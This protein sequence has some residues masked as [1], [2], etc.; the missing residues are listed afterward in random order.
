MGVAGP[1]A[2]ST[3]DV[4]NLFFCT[5]FNTLDLTPGNPLSFAD[6][7]LLPLQELDR[8]DLFLC[9]IAAGC[10]ISNLGLCKLSLSGYAGYWKTG[11]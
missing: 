3:T 8:R 10:M 2:V 9:K 7:L 6:Q 1:D 4:L 5:F 11:P